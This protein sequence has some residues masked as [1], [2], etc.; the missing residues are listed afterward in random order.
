MTGTRTPP[1]KRGRSML[2]QAALLAVLVAAVGFAIGDLVPGSGARIEHAAPG[3]VALE[4]V[5]ELLALLAYAVLFFC[6]LLPGPLPAWLYPQRSDRHRGAGRLRGSAGRSGRARSPDLGAAAER[7]AVHHRDAAKRDPRGDL[8]PSLYRR[9][10]RARHHCRAGPW[11][12]PGAVGGGPG[13]GR[14][15]RRDCAHRGRGDAG[16]AANC[17]GTCAARARW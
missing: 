14:R 2:L 10:V 16:H 5:L 7:D 11:C 12:G 8:Q 1:A 6:R 15:G 13:P 3:W 17:P 9:C 4:V